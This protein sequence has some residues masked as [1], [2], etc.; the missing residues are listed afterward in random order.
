VND[1]L[2]EAQLS[3]LRSLVGDQVLSGD[4]EAVQ[5]AYNSLR[6]DLDALAVDFSALISDGE[7]NG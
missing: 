6:N 5:C 4:R 3:I 1:A 2:D 7:R